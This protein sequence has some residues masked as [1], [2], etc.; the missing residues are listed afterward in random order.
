VIEEALRHLQATF[1]AEGK[2]RA[3]A[4]PAPLVVGL[5]VER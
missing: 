5:T 1:A 3:Y 2:E 4:L